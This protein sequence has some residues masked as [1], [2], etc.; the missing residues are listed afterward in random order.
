[1]AAELLVCPYGCNLRVLL[2]ATAVHVDCIFSHACPPAQDSIYVFGG[3]HEPR[4]P[5]PNDVF[6]YDT[7]RSQ[8][9]KVRTSGKAP[10]GRVGHAAVAI[11]DNMY[12]FGGRTGKDFGDSSLNDL[13]V[14]DTASGMLSTGS[15]TR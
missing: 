13:H 8:W 14:L 6:R 1:M 10:C 9:S 2:G 12:V 15:E 4:T 7:M 11:G 3:E 5:L